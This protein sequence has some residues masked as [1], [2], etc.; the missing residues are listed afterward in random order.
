MNKTKSVQYNILFFVFL[1]MAYSTTLIS[2]AS[3]PFTEP[4]HHIKHA[5]SKVFYTHHERVWRALL[6]ALEEYPIA[7][8]DPEKGYIKTEV[9]TGEQ[10]W[11]SPFPIN[12]KWDDTKNIIHIRLLKG[13]N[14]V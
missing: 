12:S 6:L 3:S 1:V 9:L 4:R 7:E 5:V 10:I 8:A 14:S 11:K 13:Q 2:C